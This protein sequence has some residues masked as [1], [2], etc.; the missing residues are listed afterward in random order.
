VKILDE[1]TVGTI[2]RHYAGSKKRFFLIDYDGTLVPITRLPSEA[3]PDENVKA[4]LASMSSDPD[5]HVAIVSG[6][7][8]GTME[9]W[10]GYLPITLVAEH[11]AS[12]K[13]RN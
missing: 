9:K 3:I 13:M 7:D 4:F 5:N 12:I 11:G 8:G 2:C 6:R 10:F 1:K